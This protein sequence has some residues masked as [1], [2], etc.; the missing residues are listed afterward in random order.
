MSERSIRSAPERF[1][2]GL[3]AAV[4]LVVFGLV[5]VQLRGSDEA[6]DPVA[7]VEDVRAVGGRFHVVVAVENLG[8]LTAANVQVNA[9][10]QT[11]DGPVT[12][13]Q[14]I[15]FLPGGGEEHLTFVFEDD[16]AAQDLMVKVTGFADP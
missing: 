12:G 8:D 11:A 9:E 6:P 16:P 15:S 2:L 3:S 4:L 14:I 10:V 7:R 13:D 5:A 1:A